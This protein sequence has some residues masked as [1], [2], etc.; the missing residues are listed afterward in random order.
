MV[1]H[2]RLKELL[3]YDPDTGVFTRKL[4]VRGHKV[5]EV[6]GFDWNGYRGIKLDGKGYQAHRLAWLYVYGEHPKHEVDHINCNKM[7]NRIANLRDIPKNKNRE[8]QIAPYKNNKLGVQGVSMHRGK[9]KAQIQ[10]AGVVTYLGVH[11]TLEAAKQAYIDA[12][13][14]YHIQENDR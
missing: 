6:V 7:D 13:K 2:K 1:T 8:N 5:G 3:N 12:K 10:I 11:E 14:K 9:Y 4:Y